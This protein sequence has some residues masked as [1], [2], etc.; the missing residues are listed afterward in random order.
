MYL[1]TEANAAT[2][3]Q[4]ALLA[5]ESTLAMTFLLPLDLLDEADRPGLQMAEKGAKASG[6][7]FLSFFAPQD[8]L[9][10]AHAVLGLG[11]TA[12]ADSDLAERYFAGRTDGFRPS[13]ETSVATT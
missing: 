11:G 13:T 2:L 5:P 10:L 7:P 3:R 1:T 12:F 4:I 6:T 8:L 9:T